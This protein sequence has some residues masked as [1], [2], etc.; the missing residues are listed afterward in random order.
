[1]PWA[2]VVAAVL[3]QAQL[4]YLTAA[5]QAVV[6]LNYPQ[7]RSL[8]QK[9]RQQPGLTREQLLEVLWL[10]GLVS[11]SLNQPDNARA[12]FR[13]LFALEKNR[14]KVES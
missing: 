11:G 8:L 14:L 12:A 7:A 9:A 2:L 6:D 4:G 13:A 3:S 5:R 1:M 10:Q